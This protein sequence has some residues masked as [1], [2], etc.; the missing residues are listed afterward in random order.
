MDKLVVS[1]L[2]NRRNKHP[3]LPVVLHKY[4]FVNSAHNFVMVKM[5]LSGVWCVSPN[6][7]IE[8]G[9]IA[10]YTVYRFVLWLYDKHLIPSN[11]S[12]H[13]EREVLVLHIVRLCLQPYS[14]T[15]MWMDWN[16]SI[17]ISG[18]VPVIFQNWCFI[19]CNSSQPKSEKCNKQKFLHSGKCC[20]FPLFF[21]IST[22]IY[23]F[24]PSTHWNIWIKERRRKAK[25]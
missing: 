23:P 15:H 5:R 10:N 13:M 6:C 9:W 22:T 17:L 24:P 11:I 25:N 1:R 21:G 4:V 3:T 19:S 2:F 14:D 12:V 16:V 8:V 20:I 7:W 18:I